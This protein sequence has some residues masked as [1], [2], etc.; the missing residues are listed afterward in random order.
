MTTPM[1]EAIVEVYGPA[2]HV[3]TDWL[4]L[5]GI[6]ADRT[7]TGRFVSHIVR[8]LTTKGRQD[9][10]IL[11]APLGH[12]IPDADLERAVRAPNFLLLH[13]QFF[14]RREA[15]EIMERRAAAGRRS[16]YYVLDSSFFCATSYNHLQNEVQ[17]CLRCLG[18]RMEV[19]QATGC[20]PMPVEDGFGYEFIQRL[21]ALG[22]DGHVTFFVQ[23]Y[24]HGRLARMQFGPRADIQEVGLWCGDWDDVFDDFE[25]GRLSEEQQTVDVVYHGHP[26]YAKGIMWIIGLAT[27]L[28]QVSF[29]LPISRE[30]FQGEIPP[31][32]MMLSLS[33]ESGLAQLM[34]RAKLVAVPSLWSASIEGA[35]AKSI[36][37]AHAVATVHASTAFSSELPEGLIARLSPDLNQAASQV[38]K[39][40]AE[41]WRPDPALKSRFISAFAGFHRQVVDRILPPVSA[42]VMAQPARPIPQD[43]PLVIGD[44]SAMLREVGLLRPF[45]PRRLPGHVLTEGR[46][47]RF[48]DLHSFYF[49]FQ[50]IFNEKLY[51]FDPAEPAPYILDCGAHIGL[52]SLFFANQYPGC[53]IEA[54]EADPALAVLAAENL[55]NFGVNQARV[56]AAAVWSHDQ[57]VV[58][59]G[60][61]DDAGHVSADGQGGRRLPSVRLR[62]WLER[63]RRVG[64]LKM[65]VE[66]AEYTLIPDCGEALRAVDRMIIEVHHLEDSQGRV[67]DIL[68]VLSAQGFEYMLVDLHQATWEKGRKPP[69]GVL[70]TDKDLVTVLAWR[71]NKNNA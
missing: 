17:P 28:P 25:H 44:P 24:N 51:A 30:V 38:Q 55:K 18:G 41:S 68:G 7:G 56:Y 34:R 53:E 27:R 57:G 39:L 59:S 52:A 67:G 22:R 58:F 71:K 54:F 66:G 3:E 37:S 45:F 40:V 26:S 11:C 65:D 47:L 20:R 42:P 64:L 8:D 33:W 43:P 32:I 49:Q 4:V 70:Q 5:T 1:P 12:R 15:I 10:R 14:G 63:G 60:A 19:G 36:V 16:H 29:F 62:D 9:V 48:A 6:P 2:P 21:H 23:N 46:P 61:G 13:P 50:Q 35:L 31:N 69:F